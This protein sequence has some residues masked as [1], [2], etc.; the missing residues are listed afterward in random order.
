MTCGNCNKGYSLSDE[1]RKPRLQKCGH[2]TCT[3]CC[4]N[5]LDKGSIKCPFCETVTSC[6]TKSK[7]P[8]KN[9]VLD[10]FLA[11]KPTILENNDLGVELDDTC[12]I[13]YREFSALDE[14]CRPRIHKCGHTN[15]T[16]C[17]G[18]LVKNGLVK[19]PLCEGYTNC[20]NSTSLPL[21]WALVEILMEIEKITLSELVV[22]EESMEWCVGNKYGK[23]SGTV[24]MN[25][26]PHG[27]GTW[28][29]NFGWTS[30]SGKWE[31]G[32]CL[33]AT[34]NWTPDDDYDY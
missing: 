4:L 12:N 19:C 20:K 7:L 17:C 33:N 8:P 3:E 31:N 21:N 22:T 26:K 11:D 5:L 14:S 13:C 1:N 18:L 30:C 2:T 23:Y 24:N 25:N 16:N 29:S 32:V 27:E 10:Q 15:C 6:D 9:W 34:R 28:N